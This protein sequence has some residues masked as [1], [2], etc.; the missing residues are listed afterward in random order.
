MKGPYQ[1][2]RHDL[3]R[4]WECP[5]CGHRVTT[6]GAETSAYCTCKQETTPPTRRITRLLEL[7]TRRRF[8][9]EQ[10]AESPVSENPVSESPAAESPAAESPAA[11][12]PISVN[13]V[14]EID[15]TAAV[16]TKET[17][18]GSTSAVPQEGPS[19]TDEP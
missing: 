19:Q 17:P 18:L 1:R 13:P 11:E 5:V 16:G 2:L 8:P 14:S 9:G 12:S 3:R 6:S 10:V 15:Q 4:H 7:N